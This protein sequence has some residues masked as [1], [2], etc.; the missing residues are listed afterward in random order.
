ML[1]K[2]TYLISNTERFYKRLSP[3]LSSDYIKL[4]EPNDRLNL[5]NPS[6]LRQAIN[7]PTMRKT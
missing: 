3:T 4:L 6:K 5:I 2:T 1:S 7:L